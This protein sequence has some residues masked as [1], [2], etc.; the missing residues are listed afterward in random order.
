MKPITKT[1][2]MSSGRTRRADRA[3]ERGG[4]AWLDSRW[5]PGRRQRGGYEAEMEALGSNRTG[6]RLRVGP[7]TSARTVARRLG[8]TFGEGRRSAGSAGPGRGVPGAGTCRLRL[9]RP[10]L[11]PP[12]PHSV[13]RALA[14]ASGAPDPP[15]DQGCRTA[16]LQLL[17]PSA[18]GGPGDSRGPGHR[19]H[20]ARSR[21]FRRRHE[22]AAAVHPDAARS[23]GTVV[24]SPG[25]CV[26]QPIP[27]TLES[28]ITA[29]RSPDVADDLAGAA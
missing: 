26:P 1:W 13:D 27:W 16:C 7:V 29:I 6:D 4:G 24:G 12:S 28:M 18:N 15:R 3:R 20:A 17:D 23:A 21:D 19:R 14:P 5:C 11:G 22:P 25:T 8:H 9:P 2:V 10:G